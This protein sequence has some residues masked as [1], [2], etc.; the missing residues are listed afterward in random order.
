MTVMVNMNSTSDTSGA[1]VA[2]SWHG[3]ATTIDELKS[4][5]GAQVA[6]LSVELGI[7]VVGAVADTIAFAIDPFAKHCLTSGLDELGYILSFADRITAH[8]QR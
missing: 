7:S 2:D 8:E 1:G 5:H 6:A 4:A 3:V